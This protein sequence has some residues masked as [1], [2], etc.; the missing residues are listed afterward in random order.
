MR[1]ASE[2]TNPYL[3][4]ELVQWLDSYEG[5][6]EWT[7]PAET[8]EEQARRGGTR[9]RANEIF[10]MA[11]TVLP[12]FALALALAYLGELTATWLGQSFLGFERSPVSPILVA[13]VLGLLIRNVVGLPA[14][15]EA[16]LR[17]ALK[18]ILR[19]GVALLGIRL[20]L[21]SAGAIGVAALPVVVVSIASALLLVTWLSRWAGLPGRLGLL[22]AVGTAICGNTA[23][24]ATAPIVRATD[25]ETSYAVGTITLFGLLA[26]VAYPFVAHGL[27]GGDAQMAG[28]FLGTAIHD[29]AQVAGAGLMYLQHYGG[30][31]AL[32]TATVT[33]LVRNLFMLAVIPAMA[34]FVRGEQG[35][36][37]AEKTPLRQ[38]VPLFV[39]GF[40]A[41]TALRSAGDLGA[42]GWLTPESWEGFVAGTSVLSQWCLAIA[43]AAV[44][45][46]TSFSR[47][48]TLGLRPLA[49][50]LVA[51]LLVGAVAF[52]MIQ[53]LGA[54]GWWEAL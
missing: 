45:L 2:G 17:L 19:I 38:L 32:E 14:V 18:R 35:E 50:G 29:T 31:E 53:G 5:V 52:G 11:G 42:F 16:G 49:V 27:F 44:G 47:L 28:A 37:G 26:L 7:D 6:P 8:P 33:K 43:M 24:V 1:T 36:G 46:G 15:Y 48:A 3:N 12:G 39:F 25:D 30:A 10:E 34:L 51:A 41:M 13:I 23:I 20:S 22:I 40:V 9:E 21:A 54:V 4:P